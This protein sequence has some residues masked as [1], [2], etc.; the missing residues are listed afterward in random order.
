MP[1][2]IRDSIR[3]VSALAR[4]RRRG[5]AR[6]TVATAA[7]EPRK[8]T[9][10]RVKKWMTGTMPL[11]APTM[12]GPERRAIRSV[13]SKS[14]F[15]AGNCRGSPA[16]RG[17]IACSAGRKK[18]CKAATPSAVGIS[19][20]TLSGAMLASATKARMMAARRRSAAIMVRRWSQLSAQMPPK[21][22]AASVAPACSA[23]R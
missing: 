22:A 8:V 19:I 4:G 2:P 1:A 13:A 14:A 20:A 16:R 3:A 7:A 5:K 23:E 15:V 9:A 12:S 17:R 6:P 21:S 11:S 10:S 18:A